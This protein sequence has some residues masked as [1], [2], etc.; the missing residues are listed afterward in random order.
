MISTKLSIRKQTRNLF[1]ASVQKLIQ[2]R[3]FYPVFPSINQPFDAS[4]L[5]LINFDNGACPDLLLVSSNVTSFV[6]DVEGVICLNV[7]GSIRNNKFGDFGVIRIDQE[8]YDTH[9]E[10]D[11]RNFV[12]VEIREI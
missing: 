10:L 2:Q 3:N 8:G 11:I 12:S 9:P 4:K 1:V 7:G 6:Q 5:N